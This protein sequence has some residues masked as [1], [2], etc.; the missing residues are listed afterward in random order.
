[1]PNMPQSIKFQRVPVV[2][3]IFDLL[4]TIPGFII[5]SPLMAIIALLVR[6][7]DGSPV[8]FHQVRAGLG[9]KLF[10]VYKFRTM[11]DLRDKNGQLLP[12]DQ[13]ISPVGHFLRATSLD[14]LPELFNIIR[15]EMS[16]V[17]PRPLLAVYLERYS[18][19]QIRRHEVPPGM[20]GWAQINGR[21]ALSWEDKFELDIWYVDHWSLWLDIKI[22]FLTFWKAFIKREGISQPGEATASEFMGSVL[23]EKEKE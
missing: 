19:E 10:K 21:N 22:L 15:G 1:M 3:R 4:L 8:I 7:F 11:R 9:N 5:V 6:L 14:E 13:R 17:G 2:K 12:D 20:T 23:S 16:L 18:P